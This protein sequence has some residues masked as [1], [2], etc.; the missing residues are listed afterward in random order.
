MGF[1]KQDILIRFYSVGAGY[2]QISAFN[3][4]EDVEEAIKRVTAKFK[5]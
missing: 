1:F 5:V 2:F 4:R 3:S